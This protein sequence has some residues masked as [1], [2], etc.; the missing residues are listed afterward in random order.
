MS[1]QDYDVVV[2]G[3]GIS[4]NS[5]CAGGAKRIVDQVRKEGQA[6]ISNSIDIH[7]PFHIPLYRP[8]VL[9]QQAFFK[10]GNPASSVWWHATGLR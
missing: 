2:I 1:G 5:G 7:T 10:W 8:A 4:G 6:S 3:E 9:G